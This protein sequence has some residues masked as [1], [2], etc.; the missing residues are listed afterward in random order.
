LKAEHGGKARFRAPPPALFGVGDH[1]ILYQPIVIQRNLG[2][3][4]AEIKKDTRP[5]GSS[6]CW[7]CTASQTANSGQDLERATGGAVS[8]SYV[9]NL[10]RRL[11]IVVVPEWCQNHPAQ[12]PE[13][14]LHPRFCL[15]YAKSQRVTDGL[16]L[17]SSGGTNN[18]GV[19]VA[20]TLYTIGD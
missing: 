7:H 12:T 4:W 6:A 14:P 19:T 11:P 8:R 17:A 1:S 18:N 2:A 13:H 3:Q 9:T 16:E 15:T 10:K 5:R 20:S